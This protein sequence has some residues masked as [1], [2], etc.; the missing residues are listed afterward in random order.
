[1]GTR[2]TAVPLLSSAS[3][4]LFR[5][6]ARVR[7]RV[8]RRRLRHCADFAIAVPA[9]DAEPDGVLHIVG[10]SGGDRRFVGAE[11]D[12]GGD[13]DHAF[14]ARD[15]GPAESDRRDHPGRPVLHDHANVRER[16][17]VAVAVEVLQR[18]AV[19]VDRAEAELEVPREAIEEEDLLAVL[20]DIAR[21]RLGMLARRVDQVLDQPSSISSST[22][23]CALASASVMKPG[24][25]PP[26]R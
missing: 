20:G 6:A 5:R 7:L 10:G 19:R 2:T 8:G 15:A 4:N 24:M 13:G 3:L 18:D 17:Q 11:A 9:A 26:G 22:T 25:A 1:M 12:V 23:R 14:G 21:A 16:L